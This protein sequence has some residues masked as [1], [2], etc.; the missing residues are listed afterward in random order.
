MNYDLLLVPSGAATIADVDDYLGAQQGLAEAPVVAEIA[1]EL[2]KRNAELPE[3]DTFL[4]TESVGGAPTGAVLHVSCPY[5]AIGFVRNLLFE[6]ATPRGYAVYDP[7]L[8]WLIDPTDR[9]DVTV[10]HGGAGE[11]PYLTKTLVE[12]WVPELAEPSPFLIAERGPEQY[13]QTYRA[14]DDGYIV[15]YRDGSAKR[16]F[17]LETTDPAQVAE[18]IWAWATGAPNTAT[19]TRVK[20]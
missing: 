7:Q 10:T 9:V 8:A 13:I 5:D 1:A 14:G 19:W 11:F 20:F 6:L 17:R 16:H 2:N 3:A 4:G 15:E 18:L 12:Q